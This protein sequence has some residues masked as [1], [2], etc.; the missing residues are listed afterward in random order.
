MAANMEQKDQKM[1]ASNTGDIDLKDVDVCISED[2]EDPAFAK[3][4]MRK[5]DANLMTLF[6]ILY[7]FSYLGES[8][9]LTPPP[10][11]MFAG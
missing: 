3:K 9:P 11:G 8:R 1:P 4:T 10:T 2:H 7:L 6:S 5:V